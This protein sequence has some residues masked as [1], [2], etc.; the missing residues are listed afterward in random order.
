[1][2][3]IQFEGA[4]IGVI[5]ARY[6]ENLKREVLEQGGLKLVKFLF[7][8]PFPLLKT[9]GCEFLVLCSELEVFFSFCFFCFPFYCYVILNFSLHRIKEKKIST[10]DNSFFLQQLTNILKSGAPDLIQVSLFLLIFLFSSPFSLLPSFLFP[11]L[12]SLLCPNHQSKKAQMY[13]IAAIANYSTAQQGKDFFLKEGVPSTLQ[14]LS[15]PSSPS[16]AAQ[17]LAILAKKG[18]EVL[19]L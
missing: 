1:M 11:S 10:I 17:Q 6:G 8:S 14:T 18:L 5:L 9:E 12:F 16:P 13:T 4:R 7:K 2:I 19:G 3:R 15:S